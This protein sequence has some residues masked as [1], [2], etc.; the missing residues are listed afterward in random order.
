MGVNLA[1][2]SLDLGIVTNNQDAMVAFYRDVLGLEEQGPMKIPGMLIQKMGCGDSVV[3]LV[4]M[5]REPE[6]AAAPGGLA[7]ATGMRY[8]TM[9]I[10][11]LDEVIAACE[12]AGA[13]IAMPLTDAGAG[14]RIFIVEDPDG[15]WVELVQQG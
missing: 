3:K 6:I 10:S 11:N 4:H 8:F 13:K 2:Q 9:W 12:A 7:G 15:N 1:K 5:K 14:A